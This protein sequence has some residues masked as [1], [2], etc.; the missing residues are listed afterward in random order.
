MQLDE[1]VTV[2]ATDPEP[3]PGESEQ[4]ADGSIQPVGE[5]PALIVTP[6]SEA[7]PTVTVGDPPTWD[8]LIGDEPGVWSTTE[9]VSLPSTGA[10]EPGYHSPGLLLLVV[11]LVVLACFVRVVREA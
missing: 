7:V 10:G 4:C 1:P 2:P 3:V 11:L 5:C 6:A 9:V 8:A